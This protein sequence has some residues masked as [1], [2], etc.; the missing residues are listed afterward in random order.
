MPDLI[1]ER[2][3][4]LRRDRI[5][6]IRNRLGISREDASKILRVSARNIYRWEHNISIRPH[7]YLVTR[8][9]KF[10]ELEKILLDTFKKRD[11]DDWLNTPNEAM[12]GRT[13]IQ[14]I[15]SART[16]EEGMQSIIDQIN[17]VKYGT[18]T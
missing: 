15:S 11:I 6:N 4:V 2:K 8:I 5:R 18:F 10:K 3:V 1:S 17:N 7:F 14:E 16:A 9:S 13:P 12:E